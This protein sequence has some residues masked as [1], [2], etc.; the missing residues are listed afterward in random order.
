[1]ACRKAIPIGWNGFTAG[2]GCWSAVPEVAAMCRKIRPRAKVVNAAFVATQDIKSI[3]VAALGMYGYVTG[4][5][6]DA[7]HED[8]HRTKGVY[9]AGFPPDHVIQDIDV[10]ARTLES[11]LDEV[12]LGSIDF[13]SLDVEG[14]ELNVLRGMNI[15]RHKPRYLFV[16]AAGPDKLVAVFG[17]HY[18]FIEQITPHDVLLRARRRTDTTLG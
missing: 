12:K 13:F 9:H 18:D 3:K 11:I 5:F 7:V 15:A 16:E 10:P 6:A 1:M 2:A 8:D 17:D 14:Y 4:H